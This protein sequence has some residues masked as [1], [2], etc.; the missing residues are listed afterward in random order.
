MK[1]RFLFAI[2]S[3]FH[4]SVGAAESWLISSDGYGP[5]RIGMSQK[6]AESLM[7]VK[8]KTEDNLPL[9]QHCDHVFAAKG[10]DGI[11]IMLQEGRITRFSVS[12]PTVSTKSGVKIG[13]TTLRLKN[14]FGSRVQI[15]PSNFDENGFYYFVW[16]KSQQRGIKFEVINDQVR[17]IYAGDD[18]IRLVEGC[19]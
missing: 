19:S 13:D 1:Y 3:L 12:S 17:F 11:S 8:L 7:H 4:F 6:E 5:V 15:E 18:S 16:E 9:M 2:I 14:I 10:F